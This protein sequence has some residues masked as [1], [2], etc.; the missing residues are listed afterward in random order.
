MKR[1]PMKNVDRK[2]VI[3]TMNSE[4][5]NKRRVERMTEDMNNI[6]TDPRKQE[7]LADGKCIDCFYLDD[8]IG[9]SAMTRKNC[10]CC[11]KEM[12]FGS[13]YVDAFCLDCSNKKS[14]CR[15]CLAR[16]EL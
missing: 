3:K 11:D 5:R 6:S 15:H 12:M 9:F 10:E 1:V 14:L 2:F 8:G 4:I 13:S 7:R 16:I